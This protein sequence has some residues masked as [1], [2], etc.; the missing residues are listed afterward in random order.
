MVFSYWKCIIKLIKKIVFDF[1]HIHKYNAYKVFKYMVDIYLLLI[2]QWLT[3]QKI[4]FLNIIYVEY[5]C[6][7]YYIYFKIY[8]LNMYV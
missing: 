4:Y 5:I 3:K 6:G 8:M 1:S 7:I 2:I